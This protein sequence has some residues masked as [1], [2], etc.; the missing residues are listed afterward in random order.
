MKKKSK[1][2]TR[3]YWPQQEASYQCY[4]DGK[5]IAS[6]AS[7]RISKSWDGN[8]SEFG[9]VDSHKLAFEELP[10][11]SHWMLLLSIWK[12]P[13][14]CGERPKGVLAQEYAGHMIF[15][16]YLQ[17]HDM[18]EIDCIWNAFLYIDLLAR[19]FLSPIVNEFGAG[20]G[21]WPQAIMRRTKHR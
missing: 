7:L 16:W 17:Q 21:S 14:K 8:G 18:N 1:C 10:Q 11:R 5:G 4:G 20:L 2:D 15:T 3:D 13:G 12:C 6:A 9:F 19:R